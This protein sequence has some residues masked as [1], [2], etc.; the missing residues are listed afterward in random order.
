MVFADNI[1]ATIGNIPFL[2][3]YLICGILATLIHC[4][5]SWGSEIPCIG[6]SGAISG[7]LGAYLVLYPKSRIK[8]L[9]FFITSFY[10]PA[11]VFLGIWIV[12]QFFSG[13]ASL[14]QTADTGGVAWWAHIGGAIV[15]II[16]GFYFRKTAPPRP[17]AGKYA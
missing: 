12:Q 16:A 3:F 2:I 4:L 7:I 5:M 10:V 6:A 9:V 14:V 8:V 13:A 11:I 15:G 17:L 1:E